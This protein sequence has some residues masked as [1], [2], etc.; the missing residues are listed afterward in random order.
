M[1]MCVHVCVLVHTLEQVFVCDTCVQMAVEAKKGCWIP[2]VLD[3]E[4]VVSCLM[5]VLGAELGSL[6]E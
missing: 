5:W 2:L 4:V 6:H 3:L 1:C